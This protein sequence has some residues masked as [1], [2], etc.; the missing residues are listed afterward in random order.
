MPPIARYTYLTDLVEWARQVDGSTIDVLA[1]LANDLASRIAPHHAAATWSAR[2]FSTL[3]A[4]PD[5]RRDGD[6]RGTAPVKGLPPG[7]PQPPDE[8]VGPDLLAHVH[9]ALLDAGH[10]RAHGVHYTPADVAAGLVALAFADVG[11][12]IGADRVVTVCDPAMGGGAFLL[13]AAR[14]LEQA[15]TAAGLEVDRASLVERSLFGI[16]LDPLA[17]RVTGTCL[18]LWAAERGRLPES[19]HLLAADA[20]ASDAPPWDEVADATQGGFDVIVGNPPFQNQLGTITARDG[21]RAE[22][23]RR[24]FGAV[25]YRYT[26]TAALFWVQGCRWTRPGGRV[27]LVLPQSILVAADAGA[28][29]DAV[30]DLGALVHVWLASEAV[31]GA[32]VSVCAPVVEVGVD[33]PSAIGRS[34]SRAF[35]AARPVAFTEEELRALP[36]WAP[37]TAEFFGVPDLTLPAGPPLGSRCVAT[38]GFRDQF[39]GVVPYVREA[40]SHERDA[41]TGAV[42]LVTSGLIEPARCLWGTR[43]TR[44]AGQ[45]WEAPIVEVAD[46]RAG[47]PTL[48][49]WVDDRLVPK[50]LVATQTRVIEAA[51]DE[52]GT[53]FPSVPTIAVTAPAAD[54]WELAAVIL[55]PPITAWAMRLHAG[56]ALS[57]D[58]IKVS[59]RQLLAAPLPTDPGAWRRAVEPLRVAAAA[60]D[61]TTW[62]A[63]MYDFGRA[64]AEAYR[65]DRDVVDWWFERLPAFDRRRTGPGVS[66]ASRPPGHDHA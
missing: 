26:D 63:A 8:L 31:F 34:S 24:R 22:A 12:V 30:L 28:A 60:R 5:L 14:H 61:D 54:L 40:T 49:R 43:S 19:A 18:T 36:T 44:F 10:R 58:A 51:V 3:W 7:W 41:T 66:R 6:S 35:T 4:L 56:A 25:A 27:V 15:A 46:L 50:I 39:Y 38:A 59:A 57:N 32:D 21:E 53:W 62:R 23:L 33:Q 29:R 55:A 45:R 2:P 52:S 17:V 9:E 1:L 37:I 20:L 42:R 64:M 48:G 16:D 11:S 13:A 65:G 47:D